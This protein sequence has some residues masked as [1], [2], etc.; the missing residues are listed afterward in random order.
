MNNKLPSVFVNKQIKKINNKTLFYLTDNVNIKKNESADKM[1][2]ELFIQK[3]IND[4]FASFNFIYK[5]KVLI[6]TNE[7]ESRETIIAKDDD[8]LITINNKKILIK[9]IK[10][11]K[12]I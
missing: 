2:N 5:L 4:I 12:I 8:N 11:I 9:N 10:D 3:R 7:G 6:L 1:L